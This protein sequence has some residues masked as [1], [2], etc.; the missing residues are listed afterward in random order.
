MNLGRFL[1]KLKV[2]QFCLS[3]S[4]FQPPTTPPFAAPCGSSAAA[5]IKWNF[6]VENWPDEVVAGVTDVCGH[7]GCIV[8]LISIRRVESCTGD[9]DF[10]V[11]ADRRWTA[12]RRSCVPKTQII[13]SYLITSIIT[14]HFQFN[15]LH[16]M[17]VF[18]V[19]SNYSFSWIDCAAPQQSI[20]VHFS[21]Q[22]GDLFAIAISL[23]F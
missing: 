6:M 8:Q 11:T 20:N 9:D 4:A 23:Q 13:N 15:A 12:L 22:F 16:L 17:L 18:A 7:C 5:D 3:S 1:S 21:F 14:R 19:V 2:R 10:G